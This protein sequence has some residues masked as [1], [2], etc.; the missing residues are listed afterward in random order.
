MP[1]PLILVSSFIRVRLVTISII[2]C[3]Y[4]TR[5]YTKIPPVRVIAIPYNRTSK[6]SHIKYNIK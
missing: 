5:I 3:V 6:M 4:V 2:C 1:H